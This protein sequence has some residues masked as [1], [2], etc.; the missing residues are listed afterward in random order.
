MVIV[1]RARVKQ[2]PDRSMQKHNQDKINSHKKK[3]EKKK[4]AR[5]ANTETV[6]F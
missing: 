5:S 4:K 3:K 1:V 2:K 6:T